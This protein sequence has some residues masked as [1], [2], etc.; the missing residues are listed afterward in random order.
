MTSSIPAPRKTHQPTPRESL[1]L[2]LLFSLAFLCLAWLA[3][4]GMHALPGEPP[5]VVFPAL[6]LFTLAL[7][8]AVRVLVSPCRSVQVNNFLLLLYAAW[9]LNGRLQFLAM[10]L[11]DDYYETVAV[12]G[13][14]P[15]LIISIM[16][17]SF[18]IF[19]TSSPSQPKPHPRW[20]AMGIPF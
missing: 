1:S 8:Q 9:Y 5:R 14:I 13:I 15:L 18:R 3:F 19:S 7:A 16:P 12:V 20:H 4:R 17:F 10:M 2:R 11:M 6:T